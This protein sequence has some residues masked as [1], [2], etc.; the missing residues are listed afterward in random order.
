MTVKPIFEEH[1]LGDFTLKTQNWEGN[2][3]LYL[4]ENLLFRNKIWEAEENRIYVSHVCD[5]QNIKILEIALKLS[6]SQKSNF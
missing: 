1:A 5:W 6:Y 3:V 4:T 2:S